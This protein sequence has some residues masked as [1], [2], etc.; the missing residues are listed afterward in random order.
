[1]L[2]VP[3]PEDIIW[4]HDEKTTENK[5]EDENKEAICKDLENVEPQHLNEDVDEVIGVKV[6]NES[7]DKDL[8]G[9]D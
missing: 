2:A 9:K 1:M 6:E 8:N 7:I 4:D 3:N 5:S